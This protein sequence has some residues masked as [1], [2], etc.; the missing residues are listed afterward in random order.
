M[1]HK[2]K[3]TIP[4]GKAFWTRTSFLPRMPEELWEQIQADA[5]YNVALRMSLVPST[6]CVRTLTGT[7]LNH[8]P[9][10]GNQGHQRL[11]TMG[12]GQERKVFYINTLQT[13][14]FQK[15]ITI[16][17]F[18]GETPRFKTITTDKPEWHEW[19]G[20]IP[21]FMT[22]Y[23]PAST[24]TSHEQINHVAPLAPSDIP[25]IIRVA[26]QGRPFFADKARCAR[27]GL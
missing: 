24:Q 20:T 17:Y 16:Q 22:D 12:N 27:Y 13:P 8:E 18:T 9:Q 6:K 11:W 19:V 21:F 7:L 23:Y 2:R 25:F 4:G 15:D 10:T 3:Q 1:H 14:C 5:R 26:Y